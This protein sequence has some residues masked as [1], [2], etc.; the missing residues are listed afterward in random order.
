MR[1]FVFAG[2]IALAASACASSEMPLSSDPSEAAVV[3]AVGQTFDLRPGQTARVGNDGLV[4]GFRG[5][6]SDSRCAVDVQCVWAGDAEVRIPVTASRSDWTSLAL[7]TTLEPKSATFRNY[8]IT[9]VGLNPAPRSTARIDSNNYV[10]TLR[11]E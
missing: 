9:V 6:A 4:V 1:K 3:S 11:V 2:I 8:R 5:V 7:H 10:V